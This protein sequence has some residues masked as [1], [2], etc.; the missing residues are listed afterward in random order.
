MVTVW[1]SVGI[2]ARRREVVTK[3][4]SNA[5]KRAAREHAAAH[6]IPYTE[7]LRRV[8]PSSPVPI[9]TADATFI[10]HTAP[11]RSIAFHPDGQ[12]VASGSIDHTVRRTGACC[13]HRPRDRR[14]GPR[15]CCCA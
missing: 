11:I 14:T 13:R 10:G 8:D 7:A 2:A 15:R 4:G 1:R 3:D 5:R 9:R 6:Q 12:T